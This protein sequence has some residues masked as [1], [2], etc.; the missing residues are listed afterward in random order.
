MAEGGA[1]PAPAVLKELLQ[2]AD[3]AGATEMSIILDEREPRPGLPP[4]YAPLWGPALFIRNN[5]PFRLASEVGPEHDD[6]SAIRDV[7]GG[8]KRAQATAAGRFGIG[9]NSVYF[10]TDTPMLVSRREIHVFDLLHEIFDANGWRFPIEDFRRDSGFREGAV[11]E[12]LDWCLPAAALATHSIGTIAS[13]PAEDYKQTVFRLPLRRSPEGAKALYDDRF[14]EAIDRRALL[15][16]MADAGAHAIHFLKNI[17]S[18]SFSVLRDRQVDLQVR[19]ETTP[20]PDGFRTF[21]NRVNELAKQ[22]QASEKQYCAFDRKISRRDFGVD[23][24]EMSCQEWR[25]HVRHVARF[26]DEYLTQLRERLRRNEEKATPWAALAVPLDIEACRLAGGEAAKWRVF[27][28]LLDDGPCGC[29]LNGAFFVGPSRQRV[30][31]RLDKSD[32]QRR[33]TEWNQRLVERALIPLLHDV[34]LELPELAHDLLKGYPKDYLNLFPIAAKGTAEPNDLTE[35]ARRCFSSDAWALRLR[36]IWNEPFDLLVGDGGVETV[37]EL[38]PEWLSAYAERFRELSSD[39]RRFVRYSLGEALSARVG[40]SRGIAVRWQISSDVAGKVLRHTQAPN[41]QDVEKLLKLIINAEGIQCNFEGTWAFQRQETDELLRFEA[42]KLYVLEEPG[43]DPIIEHL[44]RLQLPFGDTYWVRPDVGLPGLLADLRPAPANVLK[45][46]ADAGLELL[47]RLPAANCH[48][49]VVHGYEIKPVVDFLL[50]QSHGRLPADLR[51]GFLVRTAHAQAARRGF[52]VILLKSTTPAAEDRALGEVW[53]RRIFAHAD[54]GFDSE[55]QRLLTVHPG[56]LEMLHASDCRV[57]LARAHEA[58][59]ILHGAR[60]KRPEFCGMLEK[61]MATA[62][63]EHSGLA[64]RA[65]ACLM[66]AADSSWDSMDQ[67]QRYTVLALPIHRCSDG[68]FIALVPALGDDMTV[69]SRD[70][71]LQSQDDIEDAPIKLPACRLLQTAN[72]AVKRFYRLRLGIK[73]HNRVEVLKE[74]LRQIGEPTTDNER[75]LRYLVRY[76]DATLTGL[77]SS[78]ES[79]DRIDAGELRA[80]MVS[81]RTVPCL[82]GSWY[83]AHDSA[84]AWHI[85]ERLTE[86]RWSIDRLAP[87]M[88]ELLSGKHIAS[89]DA[90]FRDL[91]PRLHRLTSWD[92]RK[93]VELAITSESTDLGLNDRVK[94]FWDN[95]R[96]FPEAGVVR[97]KAAGLLHVSTHTG[98]V[99]LADAEFFEGTADLPGRVLSLLAPKAISLAALA[100]AVALKPSDLPLVLRSFQVRELTALDFETRLIE[101]F[102]GMWPGLDDSERFQVLRYIDTR[103][104][105]RLVADKAKGLE[106]VLVA[107]RKPT[108]KSPSTVVSPRWAQTKPPLVLAEVLPVLEKTAE[109]VVRVWDDWCGVRTFSDV[110]SLVIAQALKGTTEKRGTAKAIY[111]WL[112][113]AVGA[114]PSAEDL[115]AL[116]A[117]PWVLAERSGTWEF[118]KPAEV[119]VHAGEKILGARF[120]VPAIQ[121]P[122]VCRVGSAGL[123]FATMPTTTPAALEDICECLVERA[124]VDESAALKVYELTAQLLEEVET[125]RPHWM[126]LAERR[127]VYRTFREREGQVT[128]LQLFLGDNDFK[129]DLSAHLLCLKA[130]SKPPKGLTETYRR[131][132]VSERETFSQVLGALT[133]ITASE[134]GVGVSY[135]RLLNSFQR[136]AEKDSTQLQQASIGSIRVLTCAGSYERLD[137]CHWDDVLGRKGRVIVEHA[138]LLADTQNPATRRLA[139]WLR[140]RC[141]DKL[142][143]LRTCARIEVADTPVP[144]SLPPGVSHLLNPWR[145]WLKDLSTA[146]S[147]LRGALSG[148]GLN[149]PENQVDLMAVEQIRLRCRLQ[150]GQIIDQSSKWE[151]PTTL[152]DADGRLLVRA[153]ALQVKD[154]KEADWLNELDR[155]MANEMARLLRAGAPTGDSSPLVEEILKTLERPATVLRRLHDNYRE[156]FIHQYQD[157]V[158]D[159]EFAELFDQYQRTDPRRPRAEELKSQMF[160]LLTA[161]FVQ[162]RRDQIRGYGYDEFSVFAELLQNAEDAY[163]QREQLGMETPRPRE[164]TYRYIHREGTTPV[165]EIE[166]KGRPFNYFQHGARHFSNFSKDVEGVLRSAG[167]FK[168]YSPDRD[169]EQPNGDTIG[170]FGLGFKCVYLLT[171]RPEIHSGDWHFAIEAG[172]LPKELPRPDDLLEDVTRIRLPLRSDTAEVKDV[173]RFLG[174]VPFLRMITRLQV[175]SSDGEITTIVAAPPE[176][177]SAQGTLVEQIEISAPKTVRGG[178][179]RLIRCRNNSHAGQ[180][181]LLLAQDGTP[182]RWDEVF[183]QDLYAALPLQARLGCGLAASHRFEVQSGR[184]HLVDPKANE[185]RIVETVALLEGLLHALSDCASTSTPL[186]E[187]LKRFWSLWQWERGDVECE[188]LRQSLATELVQLAERMP[189][190]PTLAPEKPVSLGQGPCF[191]FYELPDDFR[192]GLVE[193]QITVHLAGHPETSLAVTNIVVEGFAT[194]YRRA[195]EYAGKQSGQKLLGIGWADIAAAFRGRPWFAK[196]PDLLNLLASALKEQ[197]FLGIGKWV[198]QCQVL[199]LNGE[200]ADIH[201]FPGNMLPAEFPGSQLLPQRFLKCVSRNYN[202]VGLKLLGFAGLPDRPSEDD[203]RNWASSTDLTS[204]EGIAILTYLSDADRFKDYWELSAVFRSSWF[205]AIGKRLSTK[206]A[207]GVGLIPAEI[208]QSEIFRAWLGIVEETEEEPSKPPRPQYDARKVL[209]RLH[210]W[211]QAHGDAWTDAYVER[212]YPGARTPAVRKDFIE[213]DLSARREWITLLLLGSMQTIGRSNPEQHRNFLSRCDEKGWLDVFADG[214]HDARRWMDMLEGYLDDPTGK[215]DY[216]QW[217]KQFV[218]IYQISRWLPDYVES[219]LN[220]NRMKRPFGFDAII[221]PR[222]SS[223]YSGGGPDAPALTTALGIGACF[224]MRELTRLNIL[225]QKLAHRYCYVPGTR[226]CGVL[227]TIGCPSLRMLTTGDRSSAIHRFLVENMDEERATFNRGFDLPLLALREREDAQIKVLGEPLP[228]E[229]LPS[230]SRPDEGWR[231][232]PDGRRINLNW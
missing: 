134:P 218:V 187:I 6:F 142:S 107:T 178:A 157:Q 65:A 59:G 116:K 206:E 150:N 169:A 138:P 41:A 189:I 128:S 168:P 21:L 205:P 228:P 45:P 227:E 4:D 58:I 173:S 22:E 32:A 221:S 216:Y 112:D 183:S 197:Q 113:K 49:Q 90:Q 196:R 108:W 13:N 152:A 232:L 203:L 111:A 194:A 148:F 20:C 42:S 177:R 23:G 31:Y 55:L 82:D 147:A 34:S 104:L 217:M 184:T 160:T 201:E 67:A 214:E 25:F 155:A 76:Y 36:D 46:T 213:K 153:Q 130:D 60:L 27:L 35:F 89:I 77:D 225:H 224:V 64:E 212:V 71:R 69:V 215:H 198:S 102:E 97:S 14:P 149:F 222:T 37:V 133:V 83:A 174:L 105:S 86:Q 200:G 190:V 8:H 94:L 75:M 207:A 195:C 98:Q 96:D 136:L 124:R 165:L 137:R 186:S 125:L 54:P 167:S 93:I 44:R 78:G 2:N 95:K 62:A 38:V 146:E 29:I 81:A 162:A 151:G 172:C 209:G 63:Q 121:M 19:V 181:A 208:I 3:D 202:E 24:K 11:K 101:G 43:G 51:L 193:A 15:A 182:A 175:Y 18:I 99:R 127:P 9:F 5:S 143:N 84:E 10:L 170:R 40:G 85:A 223:L 210:E 192:R 106:T 179:V 12:V 220:V 230:S 166:H 139:D 140:E 56:S 39:R 30:E 109:A 219:F 73:A 141:P 92:S 188:R 115:K 110:F 132:G 144:I 87:L 48:D 52:G 53:F 74:T 204:P 50:K 156:H 231:T 229:D 123:G 126:S 164:I 117:Q 120:W 122:D 7:A 16:E 118:K 68:K 61:E 135:G 199:G 72:A 211:W 176:P 158:A 57:T 161:K 28:P 26:D 154:R 159:P 80:L 100:N 79:T 103:R 47:Q 1:R 66:D 171:D 88:A 185:R 119:L 145:R 91:L 17:C 114:S 129:E 163:L 180:L 33:K 131:L 70:F 226:V 191:Y